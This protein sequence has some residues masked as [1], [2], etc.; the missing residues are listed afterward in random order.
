MR[1]AVACDGLEVATYFVQSTNYMCYTVDRGIIVDSRNMPA[2]DQPLD[3]FIELMKSIQMDTLIVGR[4]E[5]D[6]ATAF[7]HN[8]IEIVAGAEGRALDVVRSYVSNTLSGI[9]EHCLVGDVD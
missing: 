3:K 4:I 5:Y 1:I 6:M 8:G 9:S 2:F 7:C